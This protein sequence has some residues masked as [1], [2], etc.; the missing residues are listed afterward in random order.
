MACHPS[1]VTVDIVGIHASD[2]GR[3]CESH[4]ICGSALAPD[5]V[6]RLRTVQV[7]TPNKQD[8]EEPA[9]AVYHVTGGIDGCRVG[10]LRQHLLRCRDEYDGRL[11]QIT[12]I[13]SKNSESPSD[14]A[15]HHCNKGC[16]CAVLI[17]V[18]YRDISSPPEKKPKTQT[19][20]EEDNEQENTKQK[21]QENA[22]QSQ[23]TKP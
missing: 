15:K 6:V 22:K 19:A 10:F 5:V 23:P 11:S 18:E 1:G 20:T 21:E 4:S 9:I 13:F 14:R 3:S 2:N 12:E 7:E 8:P 16:C 17:E